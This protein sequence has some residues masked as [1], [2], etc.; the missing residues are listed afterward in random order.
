VT[1]GGL[2]G[3]AISGH[4]SQPGKVIGP[5][6]A[7]DEVA[8]VVEAVIE[9]YRGQRNANERFIDTVKRVGLD[10]FKVAANATRRSTAQPA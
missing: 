3:S 1:L 9:T 6:F 8:D 10:P 2:D 4:A 7:A 5:S